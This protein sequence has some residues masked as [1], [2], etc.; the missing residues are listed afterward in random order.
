MELKEPAPESALRVLVVEDNEDVARSIAMLLE[1]WGHKAQVVH[2]A[3][4]ALNAAETHHPEVVLMDIGLPGM[5]GYQIAKQ[6]RQQQ[7]GEKVVLV[8]LTGFGE[9]E[10]R[11]RSSEA[12]FN[13]HLVK[14]VDPDVLQQFLSNLVS[15]CRTRRGT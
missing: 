15:S 8:A 1:L 6:L 7:G 13:H 5:D 4:S 10:D 2:E 14:P 9:D 3:Q 12:G 11:R